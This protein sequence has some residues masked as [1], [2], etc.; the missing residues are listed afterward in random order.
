M[1]LPPSTKAKL[2]EH[3]VIA[4]SHYPTYCSE[5]DH[6][7]SCVDYRAKHEPYLQQLQ[8][9]GMD[10][11]FSGHLHIY[12]RSKQICGSGDIIHSGKIDEENFEY[13]S[14]ENCT[15]FIIEGAAGN[16]YFVETD[17]HCN[18]KDS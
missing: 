17:R 10:L 9:I 1:Q 14:K 12:E 5:E 13:V 11:L 3:K 15:I 18:F 8:E 16:N 7:E 6:H 2:K 4:F